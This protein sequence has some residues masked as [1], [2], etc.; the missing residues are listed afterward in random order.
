MPLGCHKSR[1]VKLTMKVVAEKS[2]KLSESFSPVMENIKL[3]NSIFTDGSHFVFSHDGKLLV[4]CDMKKYYNSN[5]HYVVLFDLQ[6]DT[7]DFIDKEVRRLCQTKNG[8]V[9]LKRDTKSPGRDFYTLN[10]SCR[11]WVNSSIQPLPTFDIKYPYILACSSLLLIINGNSLQVFV[12]DLQQWFK[13]SLVITDDKIEASL[14]TSYAIMNDRLYICYT[15]KVTLY[16]IDIEEINDAIARQSQPARLMTLCPVRMLYPVNFIVVH[17]DC[18][19]ALHINTQDKSIHRAWYCSE[20]CDH[21]HVITNSDPYI[22]GQWFAMEDGKAAVA[23]MSASWYMFYGWDI[24]IKIHQTH[25]I[26]D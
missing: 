24:T 6:T 20:G 13:F 21:W 23:K 26:E 16:Y 2:I 1:C 10:P 8:F 3:P 18:L 22:D 5:G 25:L 7:L 4:L 15:D 9:A 19:V 11:K 12:F 17:E 14:T